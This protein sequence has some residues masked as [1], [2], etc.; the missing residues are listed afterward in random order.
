MAP[1]DPIFRISLIG[2]EQFLRECSPSSQVGDILFSLF[3]TSSSLRTSRVTSPAAIAKGLEEITVSLMSPL[4]RTAPQGAAP[5]VNPFCTGYDVWFDI[6]IF[7]SK[8]RSK[9]PYPSD[10][11]IKNKQEVVLS[12][13]FSKSLQVPNRWDYSPSRTSNWL[14]N[15]CCYIICRM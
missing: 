4:T 3:R 7:S 14:N 2:G 13:N 15:Y 5:L 1:I 12:K 11:L 6:K 9:T 10:D 8:S